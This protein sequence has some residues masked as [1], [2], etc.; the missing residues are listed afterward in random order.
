MTWS[1]EGPWRARWRARWRSTEAA[2]MT[3]TW[4]MSKSNSGFWRLFKRLK[5][6]NEVKHDYNCSL[7]AASR[8]SESP[9]GGQPAVQTCGFPL[10]V[11]SH[12]GNSRKAILKT[13]RVRWSASLAA[14]CQRFGPLGHRPP[15]PGLGRHSDRGTEEGVWCSSW[16]STRRL[17]DIRRVYL[18]QLLATIEPTKYRLATKIVHEDFRQVYLLATKVVLQL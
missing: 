3:S 6:Y 7:W 4:P 17:V 13:G 5:R 2:S 8:G 16:K 10:P 14:R 18:L 1:W 9:S 12:G 15:P 11:T